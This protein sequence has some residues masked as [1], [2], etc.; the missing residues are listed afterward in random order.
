MIKGSNKGKKPGSMTLNISES[1]AFRRLKVAFKLA[2]LLRH[3]NPK[4]YTRL[5]TNIS[6]NTIVGI[7]S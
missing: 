2:S 3:F 6:N 4:K 7:I 1:V 5:E